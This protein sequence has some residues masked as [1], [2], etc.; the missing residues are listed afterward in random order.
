M[1]IFW[2]S[3]NFNEIINVINMKMIFLNLVSLSVK[4][5]SNTTKSDKI[6]NNF[7]NKLKKKDHLIKSFRLKIIL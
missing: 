7:L 2:F 5:L 6:M 4:M 1:N 3:K